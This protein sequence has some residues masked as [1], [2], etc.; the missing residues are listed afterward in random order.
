MLEQL[1]YIQGLQCFS[2]AYIQKL[3]KP[4]VQNQHALLYCV[5]KSV[6]KYKGALTHVLMDGKEVDFSSAYGRHTFFK[7]II[8]LLIENIAD[9]KNSMVSQTK[10]TH[11]F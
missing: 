10:A 5:L 6:A 4:T 3:S 2:F 8:T 7:Q 9:L 1:T 11:V